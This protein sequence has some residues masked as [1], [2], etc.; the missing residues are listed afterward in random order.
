V[1]FLRDDNA[2]FSREQKELLAKV[3]N[4]FGN[5]LFVSDDI[6]AYD[7][8]KRELLLETYKRSD[9]KVLSAE[10]IDDDLIKVIYCKDGK[11]YR[12]ILNT[13]TGKSTVKGL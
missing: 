1:F 8:E 13:D 10:Y 7:A 4:M 12:L 2:K 11:N 3:N 5:L 6:G 9:E